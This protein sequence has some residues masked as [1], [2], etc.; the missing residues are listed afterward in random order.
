M[1]KL[2]PI[3]LLFLGANLA[4]QD[5]GQEIDHVS[6][7]ITID[8]IVVPDTPAPQLDPAVGLEVAEE[9]LSQAPDEDQL[10]PVAADEEEAGEAA[11]MSDALPPER[12]EEEEL[13]N[14]YNLY[15]QL[16][17]DNVYDEAD[18]VA[19]RVVE[20]AIKVKGADSIDFAKALTNLA[21]VQN[22]T[23][24]FDAAQQNFES[25]IE[26]IENNEDQLNAQLVYPLRGLGASQ[27]EGGRP[28]KA[29]AT[30]RRAIHVTHVNLG[31]H[32]LGQVDILESLS[33]T[34]L[35]LGSVDD[36]KHT[37]D[38]I[39][40]LNER[41]YAKNTIE[42]VP[43]LM[44]RAEWQHRAGF[45]N[46]QRV[47][48]RRVIKII[49]TD[50]GKDDM[51][52][53]SPLTQLGQSHFYIDLSGAQSYGASLVTTG[54]VYFKRALRIASAN[55]DAN[56]EM[57]AATSLALGNFYMVVDNSARANRIYRATWA[58]L[59]TG[60]ERLVYRHDNL[61]RYVLLQSKPVPEYIS[62][63]SKEAPTGQE[64][65]FLQ[66]TVTMKYDVS[67]RGRAANLKI[68]E[69]H[70]REFVEMQVQVQRELR[71]R[72]FR[73]QFE[74]AQA[75]STDDQIFVH[76]FFYRQADLDALQAPATESEET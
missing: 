31:P 73:P 26:I 22:R 68:V 29:G 75:V 56:W 36:A 57:I 66:G 48:L 55:P 44:R 50:G 60:D 14:Q 6:A 30:F 67:N 4:A 17:E 39:H 35:R 16:M 54:E 37:Q 69:A 63:P 61:E 5:E 10:V 53:V 41:A 62:P 12:S 64:I 28:D 72:I 24:Q 3:I 8:D 65:P 76:R 23:G 34:H 15:L 40:A 25:A 33:E 2:T 42:M 18:S 70:P 47:T 11:A 13:I 27:L 43:G 49:E 51:R 32:N 71:R 21:V 46:D 58:D 45:I 1:M 7:D 74:D 59:S 38:M 19:K 9:P 52:L 20:L